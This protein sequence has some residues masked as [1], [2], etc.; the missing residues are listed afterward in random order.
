[1]RLA[2][3]RSGLY[4]VAI[5]A[6]LALAG[7][8]PGEP[9]VAGEPP[10]PPV[11]VVKVIPQPTI[12]TSELPGR[13]E[14]TRIAEVRA[15]VAGIVL[16]RAFREGSDVKAG[17]LLFRIDPAPLQADLA[18]AE[19]AL[20]RSEASLALARVQATRYAA[21][22]KSSA[23]SQQ[24][25]DNAT[26]A[27][28]LGEAEVAAQR[29]ARDRA[30]LNLGYATVVAPISGRIGRALVTEGALVGQGESTPM[31]RIQQLDPIYVDFTQPVSQLARLRKAFASGQL[32]RAGEASAKVALVLEDGSQ[33]AQPGRMLF[34]D[35]T[36][37]PGTGQVTLRAQFP[38][39]ERVLLPG[40]YVRVRLEQGVEQQAI[41][42]PQQA[43][44][45][46]PD[47]GGSVLVVGADNKPV[48]R[49]VVTDG[50]VGDEYIV[51][52]GLAAGETV[53]VD[54]FQKIRPG[55]TVQPVPW[56]KAPAA[57]EPRS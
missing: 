52:D 11:G 34:S 45:R 33:Y 20:A 23:I 25:Y 1:M 39:A 29:A 57:A 5:G 10:P 50:T 26:A 54:G 53:V 24:E 48:P 31:A 38:N 35:A 3:Q 18:A 16:Q 7:C 30:R 41:R 43:V 13:L 51:R 47:G 8:Q 56:S 37:D 17:Q 40:M 6:A 21:L 12:V 22:V 4:G 27:Q 28:K 42:I 9:P 55:A 46:S 49:A 36:V 19:A 14:P 15:R 44:Q 2:A 32:E